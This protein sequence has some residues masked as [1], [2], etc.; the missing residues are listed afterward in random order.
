MKQPD[1]ISQIPD[2]INPDL[3]ADFI[4]HRKEIRH[5]LT[6]TATTY[7]L[8]RLARFHESGIDVNLSLTQA[9]ENGWQGV[10]EHDNNRRQNGNGTR[11]NALHTSERIADEQR[12]RIINGH[13]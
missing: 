7:L 13:G 11:Q 3:W 6:P 2:Y 1:L 12:T 5:K 10:F 8:K 4:Q 9:I